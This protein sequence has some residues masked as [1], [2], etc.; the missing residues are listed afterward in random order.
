VPVTLEP[1]ETK[2]FRSLYIVALSWRISIS[3]D[4]IVLKSIVSE[5]AAWARGKLKISSES[6]IRD[7]RK[8]NVFLL[9]AHINVHPLVLG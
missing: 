9:E 3:N 8:K 6:N 1:K 2:N 5:F 4:L 7:I